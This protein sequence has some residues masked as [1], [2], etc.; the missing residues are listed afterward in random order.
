M[1]MCQQLMSVMIRFNVEEDIWLI[2]IQR[3][4]LLMRN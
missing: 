4:L 1:M 2:L 3:I